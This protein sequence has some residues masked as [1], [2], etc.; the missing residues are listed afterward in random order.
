M[1]RFQNQRGQ[2]MVLTLVFMT[3]ATTSHEHHD[4]SHGAH[5]AAPGPAHPQPASGHH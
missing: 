5:S 4:D 2:S 1:T 3:M